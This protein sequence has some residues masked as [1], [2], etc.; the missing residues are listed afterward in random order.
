ME[1]G[2]EFRASNINGVIPSFAELLF[3]NIGCNDVLQMFHDVVSMNFGE[4]TG[5][6]FG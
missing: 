5:L 3:N 1:I 6:F 2:L 4:Y